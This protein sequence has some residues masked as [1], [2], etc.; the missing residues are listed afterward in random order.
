M[1]NEL[2]QPHRSPYQSEEKTF[3][4]DGTVVNACVRAAGVMVT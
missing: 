1:I 2:F 3:C 4:E